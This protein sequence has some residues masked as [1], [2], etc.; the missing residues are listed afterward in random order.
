MTEKRAN[1]GVKTNLEALHLLNPHAE[2]GARIFIGAS[3]PYASSVTCQSAEITLRCRKAN[4]MP[5]VLGDA[6]LQTSL[7]IETIEFAAENAHKAHG[8]T[9]VLARETVKMYIRE[10]FL[11]AQRMMVLPDEILHEILA[12]Y[13]EGGDKDGIDGAE[14]DLYMYA[15]NEIN[16]HLLL[17]VARGR[18]S[19]S[20]EENR[21]GD[22][23]AGAGFVT[24]RP[25]SS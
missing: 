16:R 22:V 10:D 2:M 3:G 19:S 9:V 24:T 20:N 25:E 18:G 11:L 21:V 5:K 12:R 1:Q 8:K 15:T 14:L 4:I 6:V 13:P 7:A 17:T 23:A